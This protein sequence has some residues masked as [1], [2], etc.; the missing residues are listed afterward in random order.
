M[1]SKIQTFAFLYT[2]N[3]LHKLISMGCKTNIVLFLFLFSYK[4]LLNENMKNVY[5]Q[6][7]IFLIVTKIIVINKTTP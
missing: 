7:V 3:F 6:F 1:S 4:I 5:D 2:L